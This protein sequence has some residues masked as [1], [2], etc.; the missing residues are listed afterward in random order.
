MSL[1]GN[2]NTAA[3]VV[4][5]AD[6]VGGGS[7]F[8]PWESGLYDLTINMAFLEIAKSG[9]I[10]VNLHASNTEGKELR[11]KLWIQSGTA[12]GSKTYY[13]TKDGTKKNLPGFSLFRAL[14]LMTLNAE[15]NAVASE[16]KVVKLWSS[17]AKAEVPTTV[18]VLTD[19]LGKKI[20]EHDVKVW[21]V[22]TGWTGGPYGVG[23][24]FKIAHSRAVIRAAIEGDLDDVE[25]VTDPVFGLAVPAACPGIPTELLTPRSTWQ[26][27]ADYDAKAA[28]LARLFKENFAEY[29][30]QA[31]P[32][33]VAAGPVV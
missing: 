23:E 16:E 31:G 20:A 32:D 21:L 12:K 15:P 7:K 4:E 18:P 28:N 24:R 10:A 29:A 25:F 17:A 13:E 5:D 30:E 8:G 27:T 3:D 1:L 22:N 26:D 19:L 14:T 11:E 9:A 2:L 6:S 33:I